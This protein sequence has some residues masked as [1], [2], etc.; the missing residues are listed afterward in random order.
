MLSRRFSSEKPAARF[1][2]KNFTYVIR[3]KMSDVGTIR[4]RQKPLWSCK[5]PW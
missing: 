4:K 1:E 5:S 3:C 2:L